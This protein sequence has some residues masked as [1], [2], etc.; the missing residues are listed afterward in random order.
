MLNWEMKK[1][2]KTALI[3]LTAAAA[4]FLFV[5]PAVRAGAATGSDGY[6]RYLFGTCVFFVPVF[7]AALTLVYAFFAVSSKTIKPKRTA[8]LIAVSALILLAFVAFILAPLIMQSKTNAAGREGPLPWTD[9]FCLALAYTAYSALATI[10]LAVVWAVHMLRS[11][12]E[13]YGGNGKN[14]N[15]E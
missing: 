12:K 6:M 11:R 9:G 3:I 1:W 14:K 15:D 10:A 7:G 4:L 5:F 2:Q 13:L 8:V